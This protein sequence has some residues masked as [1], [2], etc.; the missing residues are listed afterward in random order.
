MKIN[1][2]TGNIT[3]KQIKASMNRVKAKQYIA[4]ETPEQIEKQLTSIR[5]RLQNGVKANER[6][7][8]IEA[9]SKELNIDP[10]TLQLRLWIYP[11][12]KNMF[13]IV[14]SE[15]DPNVVK[16]FKMLRKL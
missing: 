2:F 16:Y 10:T 8:S 11:E 15:P 14:S 6:N 1:S 12:L 7:L 9:L 4:K 13:N 3:S 5:D